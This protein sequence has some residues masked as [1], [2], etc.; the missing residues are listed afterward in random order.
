[1]AR[2]AVAAELKQVRFTQRE[3]EFVYGVALKYVRNEDD[4]HDVA[5]EAMILAFRC[6]GSFRGDSRFTTWLYRIA[7][8][9][10]LMHLRRQRRRQPVT[11]ASLD[12]LDRAEA[13]P[14]ARDSS[15][16]ERAAANEEV[17]G[18]H[19]RLDQM[20]ARYQEVF[21]LRFIEGH[22]ES[23]IASRLGLTAANVK[24]R[25]YR[26]RT[27]LRG[28]TTPP[29]PRRCAAGLEPACSSRR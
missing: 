9:T 16:E 1:M 26:A 25:A 14:A 8:T 3:R 7:A 19:A 22:S 23:E 20:G 21:R 6:Q 17:R 18:C 28:R 4:A 13:E 11:G 2:Q 24:T 15:P 10:A 27:F 12:D 5:Q 29:T